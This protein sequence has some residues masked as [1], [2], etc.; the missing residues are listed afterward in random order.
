[1]LI[2]IHEVL[3]SNRLD[4]TGIVHVG[5]H[6]CDEAR[7]Y[8]KARIPTVTWIEGDPV[9]IPECERR[10]ARYGHRVIEAVVTDVDGGKVTFHRANNFQSSS[11]YDLKTH[12][13]ASPE[14]HY[15]DQ[16]ELPTRTLDSLDD[17]H[18]GFVGNMI[19][20]D[21][22]G[23]DLLALKGAPNLLRRIDCVYSEF[24]LDELYAG[25]GRLWEMDDY[26]RPFG[27]VRTDT[28][29]AGPVGWG[30]AAWC[31]YP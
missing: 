6:V 8:H 29:L 21:I 19:N 9:L 18:H 14:V 5:A 25:C 13:E 16:L 3:R 31:K 24:N 28:K 23:A 7:D 27:F 1:M 22:Q 20:V 12:R 11:I 4:V 26:L 15:V 10:A 2:P 30:D 17:E